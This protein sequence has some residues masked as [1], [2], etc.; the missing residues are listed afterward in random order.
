M[1]RQVDIFHIEILG[2]NFVI[3]SFWPLHVIIYRIGLYM[4]HIAALQIVIYALYCKVLYRICLALGVTS[5][6]ILSTFLRS[7]PQRQKTES[8]I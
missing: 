1:E 4:K 3:L 5:Q 6:Y 2:G 8:Y 7:D